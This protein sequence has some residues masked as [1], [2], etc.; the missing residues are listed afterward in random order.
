VR[1]EPILQPGLAIVMD[2]C[3]DRST[4]FAEVERLLE[5]RD[6]GVP[7]AAAVAKLEE[8]EASFATATPEGVAFPHALLENTDK[9]IVI[10]CL[11]KD[12][13][14][15]ADQSE[16]PPQDLVFVMIGSADRPWE[17]VRL[18]AR[19]ARI[20]RTPGAHDRLRA[21]SNPNELLEALITEDRS[22]G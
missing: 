17:H 11:I 6:A 5:A 10:P 9:T 19:L 4:L 21:A 8:R 16:K 13:L 20:V 7:A 15:W 1:L 22:H 14:D 3:R 12:A 18:L 2:R